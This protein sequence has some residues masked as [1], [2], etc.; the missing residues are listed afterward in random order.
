MNM[1]YILAMEY[2]GH[3][4][5]DFKRHQVETERHPYYRCTF[6]IKGIVIAEASLR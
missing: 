3:I 1:N 4:T 2:E 6:C 5:M